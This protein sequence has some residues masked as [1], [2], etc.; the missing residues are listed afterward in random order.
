MEVGRAI[1]DT[2]YA[3]IYGDVWTRG[4]RFKWNSSFE[5]DFVKCSD[6]EVLDSSKLDLKGESKPALLQ[7]RPHCVLQQTERKEQRT[8]TPDVI[9]DTGCA[10]RR[11]YRAAV[12]DDDEA[13]NTIAYPTGA[14]RDQ[15][16]TKKVLKIVLAVAT[17]V[18]L[19]FLLYH[20]FL[21]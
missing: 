13:M 7:C 1:I 20:C 10:Y 11:M 18:L 17:L 16:M 3:G 12:V 9:V 6:S 14:N 5:L 4:E 8:E 15:K 19:S 2:L 21:L